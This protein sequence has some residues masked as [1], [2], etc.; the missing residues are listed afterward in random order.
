MITTDV[1]IRGSG[2]ALYLESDKELGVGQVDILRCVSMRLGLPHGEISVVQPLAAYTLTMTDH[3]AGGTSWRVNFGAGRG[4]FGVCGPGSLYP[5]VT[6]V[7]GIFEDTT[8]LCGI[9]GSPERNA[10]CARDWNGDDP[11]TTWRNMLAIVATAIRQVF[12]PNFDGGPIYDRRS[13]FCEK[14][15]L[16]GALGGRGIIGAGSLSAYFYLWYDDKAGVVRIMPR[17]VV[18]KG[19]YDHH[20][21]WYPSSDVRL[22]VREA[23]ARS[24]DYLATHFMV[25]SED[26]YR[27]LRLRCEHRKNVKRR[28]RNIDY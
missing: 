16:A 6:G 9:M 26:G 25:E 27:R 10:M 17:G 28:A 18:G 7:N 22:G 13:Y 20:Q 23:Y 21:H 12:R 2:R 19:S 14:K 3:D 5:R 1:F 15:V 11:P 8:S 4:C 24:A